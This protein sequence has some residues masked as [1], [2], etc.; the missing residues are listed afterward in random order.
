VFNIET[1]VKY[2]RN[3]S[4]MHRHPLNPSQVQIVR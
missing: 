1:R 4:Y 3:H 2:F